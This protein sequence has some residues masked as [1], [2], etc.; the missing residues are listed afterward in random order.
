MQE[1]QTLDRHRPRISTAKPSRSRL[2]CPICGSAGHSDRVSNIVRSGRGRLVF[3]NGE[4]AE[5]ETDLARLL[6]EPARP[7]ELPLG[8]AVVDALL[9]LL[10]LGLLIAGLALVRS[11][12]YLS[13]PER[14]TEVA[15]NVALAWFGVLIPGVLILRYAQ[16]RMD[17]ER[18]L[19]AWR[20]AHRRW[21]SL[22][23]CSRDDVVFSSVL[24]G[25]VPPQ[26][27]SAMLYPGHVPPERNGAFQPVRELRE[28]R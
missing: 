12:D 15:R 1:T 26:E 16:S 13:V 5:Y 11:Q 20:Q 17:R 23:Y 10:V 14:A 4:V 22:Y 7:R 3:A 28:V 2:H 19:P 9:P 27:M 8:R 24:S 21:T 25:A 18:E 6:A